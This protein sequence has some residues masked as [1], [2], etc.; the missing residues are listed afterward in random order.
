MQPG[1]RQIVGELKK[2]GLRRKPPLAFLPRTNA[3]N[4][5]LGRMRRAPA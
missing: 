2:M 5:L 3:L 4:V 1:H